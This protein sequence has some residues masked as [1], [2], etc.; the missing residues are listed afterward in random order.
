MARGAPAVKTSSKPASSKPVPDLDRRRGL[1][2]AQ[3]DSQ[4]ISL[5]KEIVSRYIEG[6]NKADHFQML[7]CISRDV[8]WIMPG[9]FHL[10]GREA[11]DKEIQNDAF[12]GNPV[13]QIIRLTEEHGVVI[14]ECSVRVQRK[15]GGFLDAVFCDVFEMENAKIKRLITYQVNLSTDLEKPSFT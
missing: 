8:E 10:V 14:A 3:E 7:S 12:A 11:F 6:F 4:K 9:A 1:A 13:V 2:T 5:N 15:E